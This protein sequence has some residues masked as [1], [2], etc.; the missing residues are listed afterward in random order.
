MGPEQMKP[1]DNDFIF[2]VMYKAQY[3]LALACLT[4]LSDCILQPLPSLLL[5][6]ALLQS[7]YREQDSTSSPIGS[8]L[9]IFQKLFQSSVIPSSRK[10]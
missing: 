3:V 10:G 4:S 1:T 6:L 2:N 8:F 9:L 5:D 7:L